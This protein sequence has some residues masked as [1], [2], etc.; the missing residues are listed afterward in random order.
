MVPLDYINTAVDLALSFTANMSSHSS[1]DDAWVP[2]PIPDGMKVDEDGNFVPQLRTERQNS[3]ERYYEQELE[4]QYQEEARKREASGSGSP[5]PRPPS[6]LLDDGLQDADWVNFRRVPRCGS[7]DRPCPTNLSVQHLEGV[8]VLRK[9]HGDNGDGVEVEEITTHRCPGSDNCPE[10]T[11]TKYGTSRFPLAENGARLFFCPHVNGYYK[12]SVMWERAERQGGCKCSSVRYT[13]G[14]AALWCKLQFYPAFPITGDASLISAVVNL[15]NF[16]QLTEDFED[17]PGAFAYADGGSED[18]C[19]PDDSDD[20]GIEDKE[21]LE[22]EQR[23][24]SSRTL[25]GLVDILR[26]RLDSNSSR[27]SYSMM[28]VLLADTNSGGKVYAQYNEARM[29][30]KEMGNS[31]TWERRLYFARSFMVFMEQV[32][33]NGCICYFDSRLRDFEREYCHY[34]SVLSTELRRPA[35][36]ALRP[37]FQRG[38]QR[39]WHAVECASAECV[40]AQSGKAEVLSQ[41][42]CG[43]LDI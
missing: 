7:P 13:I 15:R 6:A 40:S 43:R 12:E 30:R 33:G 31:A 17:D 14:E 25:C 36:S 22:M 11:V 9:S 5:V 26:Q 37:L 3:L 34:K 16:A 42:S 41:V 32:F 28:A 39:R 4:L 27:Q 10:C 1:D 21:L 8:K 29:C 20:E 38:L 2:Y 23:L 24:G 19:P 35:V 18:D